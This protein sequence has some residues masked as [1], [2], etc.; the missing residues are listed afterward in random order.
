MNRTRVFAEP[1]SMTIDRMLM[2]GGV[3][4]IAFIV[5]SYRFFTALSMIKIRDR[6][7]GYLDGY[8]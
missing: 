1:K 2:G 6:L 4:L 3:G 8:H 7:T 5:W